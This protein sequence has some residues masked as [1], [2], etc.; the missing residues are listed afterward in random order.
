[1]KSSRRVSCPFRLHPSVTSCQEHLLLPHP[2]L[3]PFH[4]PPDILRMLPA[5]A[6]SWV[7]QGVCV[8]VW[9]YLLLPFL[10]NDSE[11]QAVK[12]SSVNQAECQ[13]TVGA[14]LPDLK[15]LHDSNDVSFGA[16]HAVTELAAFQR[17][18]RRRWSSHHFCAFPKPT[19]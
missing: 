17:S 12:Q 15:P 13:V 14:T 7:C 10:C 1:M 18:D 19:M 5:L 8:C 9:T 6:S 2:P 3:C 4:P 16:S 11:C